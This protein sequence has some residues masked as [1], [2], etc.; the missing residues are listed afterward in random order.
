MLVISPVIFG[1]GAAMI[2][3]TDS[4]PLGVFNLSVFFVSLP[5]GI[6]CHCAISFFAV[7]MHLASS[8]NEI[9]DLRKTSQFK[10]FLMAQTDK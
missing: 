1:F 10:L 3:V 4:T 9:Q 5:F 7:L 6:S 2:L 8:A